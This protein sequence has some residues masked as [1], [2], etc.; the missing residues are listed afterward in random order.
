MFH[1]PYNLSNAMFCK[2]TERVPSSVSC[3]VYNSLLWLERFGFQ[4]YILRQ[5]KIF[6]SAYATDK[7]EAG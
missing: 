3:S 2:L 4:N 6:S 1:Y 7:F 5:D